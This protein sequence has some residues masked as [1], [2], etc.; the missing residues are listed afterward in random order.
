MIKRCVNIDWLECYC[1]EDAIN[2]PHNADY[3]RSQG[4][5]VHERE[6]GTP[7]Y[8]EMFVVIGT[9][10]QPLIE[11]RRNPKSAKGRQLHGVLDPAACHIRLT[12]RTC[13]FNNPASLMQQFL[14]RYG[15]HFQ[16]ISRIDICLDFIKFDYGDEPAVFIDRY[17]RHKYAKINQCRIRAHGRDMWD[18]RIWNSVSWGNEKSMI[19]TKFYNKSMELRER[20]DKPYIRQAWRAA[21]LIDDEVSMTTVIVGKDGKPVTVKPDIWRVEFSIKS[22]TRKWFVMEVDGGAKRKIKS[23]RNTLDMYYTKDDLLTMFFS[24]AEHYFHFKKFKAATR[25]DR[26]ED[27]LLFKTEEKAVH[28]KLENVATAE[29]PSKTLNALYHLIEDYRENHVESDI[30]KACNI[31]LSKIEEERHTASWARPWPI[32]ELTALRLLIA[33]RINNPSQP[34][35]LSIDDT[36]AIIKLSDGLF[37]EK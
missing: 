1:L 31:L 6:Y 5:I 17:F 15:L 29:T 27:K 3:F 26:C 24:L 34:Q 30:F 13:Y 11:V 37:G 12:N 32:D 10:D 28:Y 7:V 22:S 14:E 36:R 23:M 16:R 19:G 2:Y 9:D 35:S 18:G 20:S 25:K 33:Q 8:E 4:F 21:G